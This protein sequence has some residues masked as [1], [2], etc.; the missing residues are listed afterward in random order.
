MSQTIIQSERWITV[1]SPLGEDALVATEVDGTEG[2]SRLF[3]FNL[4]ALSSSPTIKPADLLGKSV[5]ISMARPGGTRRYVNGIVVSFAGGMVTRSDY[6]LFRLT[7]APT[8]WTLGRTSD[9]KVFQ[10]KTAVDIVTSILREHAVP[11]E[12]K[13]SG[14]YPS[15]EYCVQFGETD[16]AFVERLLVEEGIFY[17]F[18]HAQGEHKLVLGD[19]A[20]AYAD[21]AQAEAYYRRYAVTM[22]AHDAV[23]EPMAGKKEFSRSHD[24]H[25][26][27]RYRQRFAGGAGSYPLVGTPE[28]IAAEMIAIADKGYGGIALSFVNYTHELPFFCDRV[29][30]LLERAGYRGR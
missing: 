20:N 1:E 3:E 18:K 5:T 30:P 17:Y 26:Y 7:L 19:S 16:L 14:T 21:C 13:L 29:L 10:D 22:A 25:A 6:R 12:S 2:V 23:D 8:L 27:D 9:Y 11:F 24:S 28:H 4:A 15:R